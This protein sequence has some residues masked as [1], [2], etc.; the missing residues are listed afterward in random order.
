MTKK[1]DMSKFIAR[2]IYANQTTLVEQA[3]TQHIFSTSEIYNLYKEFNGLLLT[4]NTCFICKL[5]CS[6]LDSETGECEKCFEKNRKPQVILQWWLVSAWL[7]R[8]LILKG[9]AVIANG[10]GVWWGRT[11][12]GQAI[13]N[14]YVIDEIYNEVNGYR[15]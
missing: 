4:P 9:E 13:L 6:C 3:L 10:Y 12:S 14:D 11:T 7:G 15:A 5:E 2:E 8:K 1:D